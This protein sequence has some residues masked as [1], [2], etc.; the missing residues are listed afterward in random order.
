MIFEE[1]I[2]PHSLDNLVL[3]RFGAV[4]GIS[5]R[6]LEM[7]LKFY[8]TTVDTKLQKGLKVSLE[9]AVIRVVISFS[10]QRNVVFTISFIFS[11]FS[12][13][14]ACINR[15]NCW[16]MGAPAVCLLIAAK[17]LWIAITKN[18]WISDFPLAWLS[19]LPRAVVQ[20]ASEG[21]NNLPNLTPFLPHSIPKQTQA[22]HDPPSKY[23]EWTSRVYFTSHSCRNLRCFPEVSF[24][25]GNSNKRSGFQTLSINRNFLASVNEAMTLFTVP[26]SKVNNLP[27]D[28][29]TDA[30]LKVPTP[31]HVTQIEYQCTVIAAANEKR[32]WLV[33]NYAQLMKKSFDQCAKKEIENFL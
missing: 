33:H 22:K 4:S 23:L 1:N 32:L 30:P 26:I 29:Q 19:T 11:R 21:R 27:F 3:Y 9:I 7:F 2:I 15:S 5:W 20:N 17:K 6:I 8:I 25:A 24:D 12:S 31:W 16:S 28:K 13:I 10:P 18:L 14:W